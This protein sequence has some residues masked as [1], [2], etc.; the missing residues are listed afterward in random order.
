MKVLTEL[1]T[2]LLNEELVRWDE[3]AECDHMA[4]RIRRAILDAMIWGTF[5]EAWSDKGAGTLYCLSSC[6]NLETLILIPNSILI[7]MSIGDLRRGQMYQDEY[8]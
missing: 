6:P 5:Q 3:D 2:I 1:A 8:W 4:R 7:C